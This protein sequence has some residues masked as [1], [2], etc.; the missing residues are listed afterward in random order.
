MNHQHGTKPT[1]TKRRETSSQ[2]NDF[3]LANT[4][5]QADA[6]HKDSAVG[7]GGNRT[8]LPNA[9]ATVGSHGRLW[10]RM[11]ACRLNPMNTTNAPP[12]ELRPQLHSL[13][14]DVPDAE[15]DVIRRLFL[16]LEAQRLRASLGQAVDDAMAAGQLEPD[17]VEQALSE[18]RASHPH[19]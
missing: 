12:N 10:Y 3:R 18:Y 6:S 8:N 9:D 7:S 1:E 11:V 16:R 19:R 14:D 4:V 5:Q 17:L 15:L 2:I 13:L